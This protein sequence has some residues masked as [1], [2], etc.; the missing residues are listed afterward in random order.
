M[1][2]GHVF[3]QSLRNEGFPPEWVDSAISYS[4]LK[5]VINRLTDELQAQ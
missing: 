2:F 3:K 5:K 1:K 4:Q